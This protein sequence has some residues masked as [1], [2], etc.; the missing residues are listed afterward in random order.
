MLDYVQK[1]LTGQFE[2]SLGMLNDC[3]QNYPPRHWDGRIAKYPFWHVAYHTLC[4]VD[5]Y[6]SPDEQVLPAARSPASG[7]ERT[8]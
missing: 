7:M 8:Q 3:I 5:L 1:I 2:A 6:L 4:F